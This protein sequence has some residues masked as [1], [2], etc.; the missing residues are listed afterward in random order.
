MSRLKLG[1]EVLTM[2][3]YGLPIY[4]KIIMILHGADHQ[5]IKDYIKIK[6]LD[7]ID[8]TIGS[9]HLIP[10]SNN[11]YSFAKNLRQGD[12]VTVYDKVNNIFRTTKVSYLL[13]PK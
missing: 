8:I 5:I 9:N 4:S 7:G 13:S 2:G 3:E 10:V 12:D 6:T 11:N 1:D